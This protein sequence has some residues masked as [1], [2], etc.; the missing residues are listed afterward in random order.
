[1]QQEWPDTSR[2]L[3]ADQLGLEIYQGEFINNRT[4]TQ[5]F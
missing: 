3:V 4:A 1:M 5:S 2:N